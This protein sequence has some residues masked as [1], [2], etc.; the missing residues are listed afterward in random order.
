[1]T[2]EEYARRRTELRPLLAAFRYGRLTVGG[3]G[4]NQG[5]LFIRTPSGEQY[6]LGGANDTAMAQAI[7]DAV[8]FALDCCEPTKVRERPRDGG[9]SG[10]DGPVL[11]DH[12]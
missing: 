1:M 10:T 8:N 5:M 4:G 12:R 6:Y 2:R 11:Y 7:C 3:E 9:E